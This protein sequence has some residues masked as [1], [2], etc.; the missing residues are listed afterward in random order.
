MIS[1]VIM[2]LSSSRLSWSTVTIC[3]RPGVRICFC[4]TRSCSLGDRRLI[5]P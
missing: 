3:T 4:A 2:S 5:L 1:W